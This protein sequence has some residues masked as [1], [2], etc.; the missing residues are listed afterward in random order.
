MSAD[1]E[2]LS[3]DLVNVSQT[4]GNVMARRYSINLFTVSLL[5]GESVIRYQEWERIFAEVVMVYFKILS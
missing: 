3:V 5:R 1:Q 2:S 4:D